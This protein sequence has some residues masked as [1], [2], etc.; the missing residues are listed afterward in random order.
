VRPVP[1][2]VAGRGTGAAGACRRRHR[3]AAQLAPFV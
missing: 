1:P 3:P 2:P